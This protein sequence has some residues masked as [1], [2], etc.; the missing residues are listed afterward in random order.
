M[1]IHLDGDHACILATELVM[2][3]K[4][5]IPTTIKVGSET[6]PNKVAV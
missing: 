4:H 6:I 3:T 1:T 2:V 5:Q